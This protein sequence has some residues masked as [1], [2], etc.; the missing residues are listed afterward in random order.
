MKKAVAFFTVG[1]L[2][3]L[4]SV[5]VFAGGEKEPAAAKT[6]EPVQLNAWMI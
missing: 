1:L 6:T 5:S 3:L 2:M 4:L